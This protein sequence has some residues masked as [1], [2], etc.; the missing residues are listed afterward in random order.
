[1][2]GRTAFYIAGHPSVE[3]VVGL[4]PWLERGDPVD[5]LAGRRVLIA[6]GALDRMTSAKGS[7]RFAEQAAEIAASVSYVRI[8]ADSHPMLR[9]AAVWHQLTTG[10]VL[11]VLFGR[12]PEGTGSAEVSNVL[13]QALAG[14]PSLVV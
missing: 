10:F 7:A 9:R 5:Q 1:M 3:A 4:A 6:H 14:Q 13:R 11:A 8:K 2:G 12:S